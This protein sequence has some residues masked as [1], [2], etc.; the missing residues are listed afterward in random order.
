MPTV[1]STTRPSLRN[2]TRMR[3]LAGPLPGLMWLYSSTS[4]S[5]L[6]MKIAVPTRASVAPICPIIPLLGLND[7]QLLACPVQ[8]LAALV[9]DEHQIL[10]AH[11]ELSFQV[12]PRLA[13]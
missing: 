9:G 3:T 5:F 13:G 2:L 1:Y 7:G 8:I 10:D 4:Q 11:P 12:D 6:S